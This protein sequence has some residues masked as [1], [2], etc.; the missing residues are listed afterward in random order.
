MRVDAV[1]WLMEKI[2]TF[3]EGCEVAVRFTDGN[4]LTYFYN[5]EK[6]TYHRGMHECRVDAERNLLI[7]ESHYG[8]TGDDDIV[9]FI[10]TDSISTISILQSE[11]PATL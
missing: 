4:T 2:A 3:D 1:T 10:D 8:L 5:K 11:E 9:D 7:I 6:H